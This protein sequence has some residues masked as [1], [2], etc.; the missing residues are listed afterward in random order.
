MPVSEREI[1]RKLIE[2]YGIKY[3]YNED[4]FYKTH[5]ISRKDFI[6]KLESASKDE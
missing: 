3:P 2:E 5:K 4:M 6:A 1:W